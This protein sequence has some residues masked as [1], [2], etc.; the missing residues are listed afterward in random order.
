MGLDVGE[1]AVAL[2]CLDVGGYLAAAV[3][4]CGVIA[5]AE[6]PADQLQGKLGVLAE[7]VHGDVAGG[8]SAFSACKAMS[9]VTGERVRLA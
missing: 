5:V 6:K 1:L 8:V 4:D 2:R 9:M 3:D 7:E